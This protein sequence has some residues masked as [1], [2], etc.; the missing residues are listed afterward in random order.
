MW[1]RQTG[2]GWRQTHSRMERDRDTQTDRQIDKRM[3]GRWMNRQV[4]SR[5]KRDSDRQTAGWETDR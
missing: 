2:R 1:R 5:M 3:G 4:N